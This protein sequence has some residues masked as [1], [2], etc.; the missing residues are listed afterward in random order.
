MPEMTPP[1]LKENIKKMQMMMGLP[2][3][4]V[5]DAVTMEMINTPRCGVHD[6]VDVMLV[7]IEAD[8]NEILQIEMSPENFI[9]FGQKWPRNNIT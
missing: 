3:T 5:L 7:P 2:M 4:G 9:H 8:N 6:P 1:N